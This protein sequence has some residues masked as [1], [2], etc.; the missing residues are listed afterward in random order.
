MLLLP[1]AAFLLLWV[2]VCDQ[3]R[4]MGY[5]DLTVRGGLVLAYVCFELLLL[6]ITEVTSIGRH[7]TA[8]TVEV[9]WAGVVVAMLIVERAPMARMVKRLPDWRRSLRRHVRAAGVEECCWIAGVAVIAAVLIAVGLLYLPNSG[10]SMVYHLVRVAHWVQNR[11]IAPFPTHY[12][13]QVELSPLAEYNLALLHLLGGTDR[14]DAFVQL[15]AAFVC[16]VGVSE[17]TRRLGGSRWTQIVS[18]VVCATIPIGILQATSSENDYVAAATTLCLL[19]LAASF[20]LDGRSL[21]PSLAIGAAV[22]LCYMAKGTTPAMMWPAALALLA[23][24]LR[25]TRPMITTLDSIARLLATRI[26]AMAGA[27]VAVVAPFVY[28]NV[29]L[30]NSFV[31]PTARTTIIST[32]DPR[33]MA[34]NVIRTI[35]LNF[36]IGDGVAGLET[37]VSKVTLGVLGP[38]YNVFGIRQSDPR[39]KFESTQYNPFVVSNYSLGPRLEEIGANPWHVLLI[40][41]SLLIVTVGVL[42]GRRSLRPTL[43]LALGLVVGFLIFNATARWSQYSVRYNLPSLV[44]WSAV[45]AVAMALTPRWVQRVIMLGLVVACLPM[46]LNNATRPLVPPANEP[47]NVLAGYFPGVDEPGG[48][49]I[50]KTEMNAD[51][52]LAISRDLARSTC[53]QAAIGN[54]IYYEYPLW[55]G[56]AAEGWKG[57]LNEIDVLNTTATLDRHVRACA[58]VSQQAVPYFSPKDGTIT[59][60]EPINTDFQAALLALSVDPADGASMPAQPRFGSSVRGVRAQPGGG[61]SFY[62]SLPVVE[63]GGSVYLFSTTSRTA[64][65]VLEQPGTVRQASPAL[66]DNGGPPQAMHQEGAAFEARL[67]LHPGVNEVTF[68]LGGGASGRHL[69]VIS[70]LNV[71]P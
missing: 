30:F 60:Q 53:Q 52:Y 44:A 32:Y 66:S 9:V 1:V 4:R 41:A 71:R 62:G 36:D 16:I 39:F 24:A 65:L 45:I 50:A 22:G 54:F 58:V 64:Q 5:E 59:F 34:G 37:Y 61:W 43:V 33:G 35:A 26:G 14:F 6:A 49:L 48:E 8:G 46:L 55:A 25:R 68:S 15:F 3:G 28:E 11:T 57:Q 31:G 42:L 63:D 21:I 2:T 70:D 10:D 12:V 51:S 47:T 69:L 38:I 27:A 40:V 23:I 13:A 18:S 67:P 19:V 20:R 29:A 56:L 17:L 7:F